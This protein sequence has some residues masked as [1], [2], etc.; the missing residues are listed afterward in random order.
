MLSKIKTLLGLGQKAGNV[1]S[2]SYAVR[3]ALGKKQARLMVIAE[4]VSDRTRQELVELARRNEVPIIVLGTKDE[5][6]Q[7]LGKGQRAAAVVIDQQLATAI[8]RAVKE[9]E[10]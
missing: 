7:C 1:I 9:E 3:V 4:D 5:L 6:G 10:S 8:R 2:G